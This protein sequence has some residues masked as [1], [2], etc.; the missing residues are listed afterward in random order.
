MKRY[1]ITIFLGLILVFCN[2]CKKNETAKNITNYVIGAWELRQA[3]NGMTPTINYSSGNGNILKFSN[4]TYEKYTNNNLIKTGYY[5]IIEDTSVGAEVGLVIPSG[6]FNH[7]I[8]YDNDFASRKTF[9]QVSN[10]KL[11]FLSGFVPLDG[12]SDVLYQKIE[13]NP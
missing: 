7:R 10:D 1:T 2:R 11:T 3:Q 12:G 5:V 4:S 13:N 8:V 6:Q 9:F